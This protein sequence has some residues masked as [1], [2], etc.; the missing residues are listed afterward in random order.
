MTRKYQQTVTRLKGGTVIPLGEPLRSVTSDGYIELR[1]KVGKYAYC[2]ALEH[3]IVNGVTV[4]D[5][6]EVHHIDHDKTNN[7]PTNLEFMSKVEH[8]KHHAR[9]DADRAAKLY[10]SGLSTAQVAAEMGFSKP[11][12]TSDLQRA[13]VELRQGVNQW[14]GRRS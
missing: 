13:G 10:L 3:R 5:D 14:T 2:A 9:I 1:W 11:G 8:A 12:V 6:I 4:A 7:D